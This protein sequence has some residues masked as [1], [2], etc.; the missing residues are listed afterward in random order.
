MKTTILITVNT[1]RRLI[2]LTL[3]LAIPTLGVSQSAALA[4]APASD[5]TATDLL[6]K[7]KT[8]EGAVLNMTREEWDVFRAWEGYDERAHIEILQTWK[9][10]DHVSREARRATRMAR[11]GDCDCWVEPDNSYTQV[12]TADWTAQGGAGLDVDCYIGPINMNGWNFDL[13]GSSFGS[14]YI[15]SKGTV[16]FGNGYIDWT[17]TEFPAATYNQ[18]AG[19]WAD[20]D[21][22]GSGELWYKVTP[23]AVYVNFVEVGYFNNKSDKVN[24]FQIIFTPTNGGVLGSGANVQLCYLDMQWAHGDVG[25]NGGF[26]G[27]TPANVGA[28]LAAT[29]GAHIQY[30]RFN[31]NNGNYNGPYGAAAAQQDGVHWLDFKS[32]DINTVGSA[33]NNIPPI[34]TQS[35]GCDDITLCLGDTLAID[36]QFLAP[37]T[38][39][40]VTIDVSVDGNANGLFITN[41][42]TGN[43]ASIQGGFAGSNA[44]LGNHTLFITATDNGNPAASTEIIVNI[45]VIPVE[46]PELTVDGNFVVC[47]GS[48]TTIT[49]S[50]G[51]ESYAWSSGCQTQSCNIMGQGTY[52]VTAFLDVCSTT[53]T[54]QI[55]TTPYFLPCVDIEPNP[56]CSSDTALVTVCG[57]ALPTYVNFQWDGNWNGL[58]GTVIEDNGPTALLTAGTFRLLVENEEGCF[59]QRVFVVEAIDAFIPPDTQSGAYCDGLDPVTFTGGFSNPA[60]G[61]MTIYLLSSVNTGWSG[62]FINI[63]IDGQV[64]NTVTATGTFLI[65]QQPIAAG[66]QIQLEYISSGQG[67]DANYSIQLFNCV[68]ANTTTIS[69]LTNGIIYN[70]PAGCSAQ[71]AFGEWVIESGP[72]GGSFTFTSQ[73]NSVFT[74]GGHGLYELCFYESTCNIPYCYLLEYT[75]EPEIALNLAEVLLCGNESLTLNATVTDIGGTGTIDWPAPGSDNVLTNTY[76]FNQAQEITLTV[77][78]TNGCGS[79][80]ASVDV[81]VQTAP[82]NPVLEDAILCDDG[83]VELSPLTNPGPDV[84]F[85]WTFNGSFVSD[86][87]DIIAVNSGV[88]CVTVSNLCLPEGIQA[89]AEITLLEPINNPLAPFTADCS[90]GTTANIVV[91]V[92]SNEWA[93]QWP[94]GST[95]NQYTVSQNG[96]VTVLITDP[97]NCETTPYETNVYIGTAPVANPSPT[98]LTFLCPEINTP[99]NLNTINGINFSWTLNCDAGVDLIGG[100]TLNLNSSSISPDCFGQELVLTGTAENPCGTASGQFPVIIDP[101][102][103]DI[104][105]IFTPNNDGI[106]DVYAVL[107]LEVYRNVVLRIYDRWG[108]LVYES[109]DY[110]NNWR[111]EDT[112]DGTYFYTLILPNGFEFTGTLN[113]AGTQKYRR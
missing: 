59:G 113:I 99:F 95:G 55:Q 88:Y 94:D 3:C 76:S 110:R 44:T 30:G 77:T 10:T 79:D 90:G 54:F 28:D 12:T 14:F 112:V 32:F 96:S 70:A 33:G 57:A 72:A 84:D 17:P 107:G 52:Q 18:I 73:Y 60:A 13:Y 49:A 67:D 19:F 41:Q 80:E 65:F 106:N 81:T 105:N 83:S 40:T 25:G 47:A 27:P 42:T 37:E 21:F 31:L 26:N 98:E 104:P 5:Y 87:T 56:I 20:S 102:I 58:G 109:D 86:D 93:V 34:P 50:P 43:I 51:F 75:E 82:A 36:L 111:G 68:A 92:P 2:Y 103:I 89:C 23:E 45:E 38:G 1:M 39:Q 53:R 22:R 63:I 101:C 74:P 85:N 6:K 91:N 61:Q 66:Q 8:Y 7:Y 15:N 108:G 97:G 46:L 71:P 69:N 35:F 24:T 11:S 9:Q 62:S 16:S 29:T 4:D 100:A 78:I 64:V 48:S